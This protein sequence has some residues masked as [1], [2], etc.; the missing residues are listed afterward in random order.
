[1]RTV[2]NIKIGISGVRGI[3][4]ETLNPEIVLN[5]TRAFA[6]LIGSGSVAVAKDSRIS[7]EYIQKAVFSSL[8][9]SGITP[10][11]TFTIPTPTLQIFVKARDLERT[12]IR[13]PGGFIPLFLYRF[14]PA[15]YL[16]SERICFTGQE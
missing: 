6:T 2:E 8:I 12:K 5:F 15:G 9:Y 4:G 1:M 10:V 13:Q 11:N 14:P 16:P 3:V 7:G